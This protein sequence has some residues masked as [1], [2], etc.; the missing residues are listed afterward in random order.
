MTTDHGRQRLW[1]WLSPAF[2]VGAYTYSQGLEYA[3]EAGLVTGAEDL[4]RWIEGLLAFGALRCQA[5]LFVR[6]WRAAQAGDLAELL[7]VSELADARRP[8]AELG[9]ES[10]AQGQA[11]LAALRQVWP[12][13]FLAAWAE[14]LREM[15]RPA[16]YTVAVAVA[17]AL[18]DV[19]MAEAL[20]CFLQAQA[21]NLVSAGVRLV[22]LGQT[23]GLKVLAAL[24]P[25]LRQA[26]DAALTRD[27]QDWGS[28]GLV[29]DWASMRHE[30]QYTRLFR[31]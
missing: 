19:A 23:A 16:A 13:D 20:L 15:G 17:A 18:E 26:R 4:G 8:T 6:A 10:S 11:F 2:P 3:V 12:H 24:E 9:L 21:A 29:A 1:T 30:T 5:L 31:S 28:A 27:P 25:R 22:P 14:G 7:L